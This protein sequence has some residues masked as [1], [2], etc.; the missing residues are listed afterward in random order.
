[1]KDEECKSGNTSINF[2]ID[3]GKL[4]SDI[5]GLINSEISTK[6][7]ENISQHEKHSGII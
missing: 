5:T 3:E 4:K 6:K 7:Y 1:M 2:K